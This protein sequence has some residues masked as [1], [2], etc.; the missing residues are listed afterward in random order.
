MNTAKNDCTA[1]EVRAQIP[2]TLEQVLDPRWLG[3]VLA[4]L[5]G[6]APVASV[7][8]TEVV[9]AMAA[10]VLVAIRFAGDERVHR[11][12]IKGFL[13]H[14]LGADAGGATTLREA[15]FYLKIAPRLSM[16]TPPCRVVVAEREASRCVFVMDDMI[17]AGAHFYSALE[18]LTVDE[19]A[20][21]LDQ[22][23]R[24]HVASALL[25]QNRWIPCRIRD[26]AQ[27]GG[28]LGVGRIQ[29]LMHDERRA[30]LP[31]ETLD[32]ERLMRGV[33]ALAEMN[34]ALPQTV[35][36][37]DVHPGNIYRMP[38][39]GLAFTD[40]QCIQSGNWS[41]DVAY[42]IAS[43]LPVEVAEKEER[44][45]LDHYLAVLKAHGGDAPEREVA[46]K[47]YRCAPV[48]GY[49]QWAITQRVLPAI[50]N[51]AFGRLGAAV[52]RHRS[53]ELLFGL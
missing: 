29:Q 14:D 11:F 49:Y 20:E 6:G 10:K 37:G 33:R 8:L 32:A 1:V 40:W 46:W 5:S 18:P 36:H 43:V 26:L 35:L 19:V 21:T 3:T 47:H 45:L 9:K 28:H 2:D 38:G 41:L 42:H 39:V 27:H 24:L 31:D 50:T 4:S 52:T 25:A 12:C 22:L 51:Q 23:A 48:Y 30:G 53:Y 7:E 16:R 34:A 13:D 17:A 44:H 15:D